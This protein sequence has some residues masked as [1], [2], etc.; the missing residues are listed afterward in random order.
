MRGRHTR[1]RCTKGGSG[2]PVSRLLSWTIIYLP[3]LSPA[4][5]SSQPGAFCGTSRPN[6]PARLCSRWGLP[7][8]EPHCPRRWSLTPPFHPRPAHARQ[9]TSLLRF[10]SGFPACPLGSTALCGGRT[11][12]PPPKRGAIIQPT[13]TRVHYRVAHRRCGRVEITR[14]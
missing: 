10:P 2:Q 6:A 8:R 4:G 12:L 7:S 1:Q 14:C 3:L 13:G 9:S 5:S 11:F